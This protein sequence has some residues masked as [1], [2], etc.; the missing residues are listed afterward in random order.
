VILL[1]LSV[2]VA[3][4]NEI[5]IQVWYYFILKKFKSTSSDF[6]GTTTDALTA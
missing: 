4:L 1:I 6:D 2:V 5:G 3:L